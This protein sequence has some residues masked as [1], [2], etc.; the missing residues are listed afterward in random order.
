M[1]IKQGFLYSLVMKELNAFRGRLTIN[2]HG[3][4]N[5][6][7]R[8]YEQTIYAANHPSRFDPFILIPT[9][10]HYS[11][12]K[13]KVMI[14]AAQWIKEKF[15]HFDMLHFFDRLAIIFVGDD[16]E[17]NKAAIKQMENH[18]QTYKH[19]LIFPEGWY[20]RD[21]KMRP[22][23]Y[24]T[25]SIAMHCATNTEDVL[26]V[27]VSLTY[28]M[29]PKPKK[30]EML[31]GWW[32]WMWNLDEYVLD[33]IVEAKQYYNAEIDINF[34][35]PIYVNKLRAESGS[36]DEAGM[37]RIITNTTMKEIANLSVVNANQL[38]AQYFIQSYKQKRRVHDPEIITE[39]INAIVKAIEG[40]YALSRNLVNIQDTVLEAL[41][42]FEQR[43]IIKKR[44]TDSSL[45]IVDKDMLLTV[46]DP[47]E[48]D[49]H[50]KNFLQFTANQLTHLPEA[51]SIIAGIV[52]R[53]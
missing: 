53:T 42:L 32:Y 33:T 24:G 22:G 25:S 10:L 26:M 16:K 35:K 23:M 11:Q 36:V 47:L 20:Q 14:P 15:H 8:G 44:K 41:A 7:E 6:V 31:G 19:I 39:N 50:E 27:P 40:K 52:T 1:H 21:G 12:N 13:N 43:A 46:P 45:V 9:I 5:I 48:D 4:E 18:L 2:Y 28:C 30:R 17:K 34:G 51:E 38:L 3:L 29:K 49:Y 37:R